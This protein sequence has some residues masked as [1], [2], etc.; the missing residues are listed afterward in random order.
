MVLEVALIDVEAHD[1]SFRKTERFGTGRG[2]IGPYFA[3]PP[4]VEHFIDVPV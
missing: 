2:L 3:H 4:Q 1:Q